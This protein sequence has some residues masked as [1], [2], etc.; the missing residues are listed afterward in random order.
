MVSV[1]FIL[2]YVTVYCTSLLCSS[3]N[4]SLQSLGVR[5]TKIR[6]AFQMPLK[7][8]A[9]QADSDHPVN[10][11]QIK[12]LDRNDRNAVSDIWNS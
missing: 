8:P 2:Q 10:L 11:A 1:Y 3:R 7:T 9:S 4:R 12:I 5:K 6:D